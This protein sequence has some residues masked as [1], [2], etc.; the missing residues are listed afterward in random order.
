MVL[1]CLCDNKNYYLFTLYILI[2]NPAQVFDKY[3]PELEMI[4]IPDYFY[5]IVLL[6]L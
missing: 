5:K 6:P 1:K 3:W 4:V 2:Q